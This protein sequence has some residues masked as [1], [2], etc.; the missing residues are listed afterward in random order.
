MY[1][2]RAEFRHI[3]ASLLSLCVFTGCGDKDSDTPGTDT[4]ATTPSD[5]EG[6]DTTHV[7]TMGV[8]SATATG[9]ER[10]LD[11][12][13]RA[14]M[15]R[16]GTTTVVNT[17]LL[18]LDAETTYMSHV[19]EYPCDVDSGGA[20]Y[21]VDPT[22]EGTVEANEIWPS[23]TTDAAGEGLGE[24]VADHDARADAQSIVVHDPSDGA[25]IACATLTDDISG[26]T[27]YIG[28]FS[29]FASAEEEGY[30]AIEG[31]GQLVRADGRT[32]ASIQVS[33]MEANTE[34]MAHVHQYPCDVNNA[35]GHYKIDPTIEGTEEDNE[36]WPSFTSDCD[37]VGLGD[38]EVPH[39]ARPDA[40]S[41]VIHA[42]SG[43]KIAC[44]D[45]TGS[46][47]D[48]TTE[49]EFFTT[50]DG[51]ERGFS[52]LGAAA[53]VRTLEGDTLVV[54]SVSGLD[55]ETEYMS[56]VHREPC[57]TGGGAHYKLDPTEEETI[58][59][60]EIWPGFTTDADGSGGGDVV[61]EGHLA[62]PEAQSIVIHDSDGARIACADLD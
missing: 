32:W 48:Y 11:I 35:G 13:G 39:L 4:G 19:H 60:N 53:M 62:R 14:M 7:V 33:G 8:F 15:T 58:E 30:D 55:P 3:L 18:G 46:V 49:G 21:K 23:F 28:R 37:G 40:T 42:P 6:A 59:A 34:Y 24:A 22:E 12:S 31:D 38:D 9:A 26:A 51:W 10:G 1:V 16:D 57:S 44:A 36:I 50:N 29:V 47:T 54:T 43:A 41:V 17:Q 5:E 52:I 45:L 56:H 2:C 25:R 20:H 61:S 27:N